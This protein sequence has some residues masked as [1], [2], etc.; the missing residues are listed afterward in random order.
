[1]SFS[2]QFISVIILSL[3]FRGEITEDGVDDYSNWLEFP[4][5]GPEQLHGVLGIA[6]ITIS[7]C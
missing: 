7:F 1:M 3:N 2:Y 6:Q 5:V 4:V